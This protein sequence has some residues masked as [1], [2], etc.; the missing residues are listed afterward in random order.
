MHGFLQEALLVAVAHLA[1]G[2]GDGGADFLRHVSVFMRDAHVDDVRR[3][4][5]GDVRHAA[6]HVDGGRFVDAPLRKEFEIL[7]DDFECFFREEDLVLGLR[8]RRARL[9]GQFD[10]RHVAARGVAHQLTGLAD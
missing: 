5:G 8:P 7:D 9:L 1:V 10:G 2:L 6:K 3:R 4:A